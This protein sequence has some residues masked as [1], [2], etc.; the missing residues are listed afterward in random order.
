MKAVCVL[1]GGMDSATAMAIAMKDGYDVYPLIFDYNQRNRKEIEVAKK[2]CKYYGIEPK[3][4]NLDLRQIGGSALTDDKI[5]VPKDGLSDG[6]PVTYVP[7]RN[8]IFLSIATS[9]AEVIGADA[10]YI[11]ANSVDYSGYPDCR[12]EFYDAFRRAIKEG[13]KVG[14]EGKPIDIK[15]P[16]Q[17]MSK[18]DIVKKGSELGVPFEYTWSCYESSEKAC[19]KCE[20]CLLRLKGFKE[21]GLDDPIKY[22]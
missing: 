13:T 11:G 9:Y 18:V 17:Y 10:V 15:V 3:I 22:E 4:M 20:S 6:I 8:I 5:N 7:S 21:N 1:S 19:G 16:L 12:P 2:L 14:V